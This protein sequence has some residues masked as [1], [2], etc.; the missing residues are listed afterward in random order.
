[1]S[2]IGYDV[3]QRFGN[4]RADILEKPASGQIVI[5]EIDAQSL[6][7]LNHWPWPREY[8]ARALQKLNAAGAAQIAFDIDFSGYSTDDQDQILVQAIAESDAR[9]ILPT[10]RQRASVF[11]EQFVESLPIE[12]LRKNVWL[13]S[14]NIDPDQRGQLNQYSYGTTSAGITRP[15]F[16]SMIT[17]IAGNMDESFAID[18]SIDPTSIPRISFLELMSEKPL[19][20]GLQGKNI[21]IGTTALE[22][23]DRYPISRFGMVPGVVIQAMASET[24]IQKTNFKDFGRLPGLILAAS[25]LLAA[26]LTRKCSYQALTTIALVTIFALMG[27]LI[28]IEYLGLFTYSN[29]V[30]LFFLLVYIVLQ[31][32]LMTNKALKTS[33]Y[34]NE[35]SRLP[36]EAA[37]LKR[38]STRKFGYI[39]TARITDFTEVL[40]VSDPDSR[41]DLFRNLASRLRFLASDEKIYHV[42][43]D[44]I[45]WIVKSEYAKDI[46]SYFDIA[47]AMLHAPVMAKDTRIKINITFGISDKTVD[48]AKLASGQAFAGGK[49]WAWYDEQVD[50][51]IGQRLNLLIELEQAIQDGNLDVVYQPKWNLSANKLDGA[52]AL[53]RW[54]HPQRGEVS[55]E[56]FIPI[57]ER[58]GRIDLLTFYVLQQALDDLSDWEK[59]RPG[60]TCS[61]NIAANLLGDSK[62]V[63]K[64]IA[65]VED[66]P[67]NNAQIVFEVTETAAL[68]CPEQS[69][70]TL[71]LIRNAGIRVSIDDYGTGQSTMSYLQRLPVNEIKL[72]KSFVKTMTTN[73]PNRVMVQSTIKMAHALGLKIVAEGIEDQA[74]M[75]MLTRY[76][77]DIGQGWYISKPVKSDA[78]GATWIDCGREQARLSA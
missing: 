55:P 28:A 64:A 32:F 4:V 48:K 65:M 5:V 10:L 46:P 73:N 12:A 30:G 23:G 37:L 18:Q 31:K 6:H 78:F 50:H 60:L 29:I 17:G 52:E 39:A 54:S 67:A 40:V 15:S 56:I 33:Q 24:L 59:Q 74:C 61:V 35:V 58:A 75:D 41:I 43:S 16:A 36:N 8:Y 20:A 69:V 47:T 19:P 72:D 63:D 27:L 44:M 13:A 62:F 34:V 14:V 3:E 21:L 22:L 77:C 71:N 25:I 57:L 26:I 51:A 38:M 2:D 66:S 49:K 68:A 11:D 1:M 42:D 45:A 70:Y 9:V 7:A 76:G 53:V